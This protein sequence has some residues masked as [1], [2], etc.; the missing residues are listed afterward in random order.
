MAKVI[1]ERPRHDR[2]G[3][4]PRGSMSRASRIDEAPRRISMRRP[5]DYWSDRKGLNDN[6]APLRRYLRSNVGRPWD[7]VFGEICQHLNLNSAVQLHIWQ[8]LQWEVCLHPVREG[9]GWTCEDDWRCRKRFIVDPRNGILREDPDYL[10][11]WRRPREVKVSPDVIPIDAGRC[12]R[13]IEGIW[14]ELRLARIPAEL[15][16]LVDV[17]LRRKLTEVS[18]A[19]L[20]KFHGADVYAFKK[21]Q[22]NSKEIRR[23]SKLS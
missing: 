9:R 22:L 4:Y 11:H 14:Y 20:A 23:L 8:H 19:E 18:R 10:R 21:T 12:C 16:G 7:K 5:W 1:V 3:R 6:L 2:S 17:A 13:R 15:R